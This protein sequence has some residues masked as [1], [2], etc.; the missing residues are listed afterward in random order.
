MF[1]PERYHIWRLLYE[2]NFFCPFN[3]EFQSKAPVLPWQ[4][5]KNMDLRERWVQAPALPLNSCVTV[6]SHFT[7]QVFITSSMNWSNENLSWYTIMK[8][9][10]DNSV[11]HLAHVKA[12]YI[13]VFKI[14][15]TYP[16]VILCKLEER[17][18]LIEYMVKKS[19]HD[20]MLFPDLAP[21][22]NNHL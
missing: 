16:Y 22:S 6:E 11:K 13:S 12:Q 5:G 10:M 2:S 4:F 3:I 21:G 17:A 1:M 14:L 15:L 19:I 20:F 8:I 18:F 7:I 9:K